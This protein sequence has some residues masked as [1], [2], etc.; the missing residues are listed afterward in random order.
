[1]TYAKLLS[2]SF[3]ECCIFSHIILTGL[4]GKVENFIGTNTSSASIQFTW[5]P[6]YH[7]PGTECCIAYSVKITNI[8]TGEQIYAGNTTDP[9]YSFTVFLDRLCHQYS[10]RISAYNQL[11]EGELLETV[12]SLGG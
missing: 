6:P 10:V 5:S 4:P 3:I 9:S 2:L 8:Q 11:G 1:M 12:W 7:V